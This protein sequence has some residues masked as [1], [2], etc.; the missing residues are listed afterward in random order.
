M[1]ISEQSLPTAPDRILALE[2]IDGEKPRSVLGVI[3]PRLFKGEN[4]LHAEMESDTCLWSFR[5]DKGALPQALQDVKF[6][7][8][9]ALRKFADEYFLKRNIRLIEVKE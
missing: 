8:Y 7:G 2:I 3:D 6:T 5:Y 9:K 4:R 1:A